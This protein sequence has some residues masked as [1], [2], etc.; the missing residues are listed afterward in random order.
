MLSQCLFLCKSRGYGSL[1]YV[2]GQVEARESKQQ[3][4]PVAAVSS[5]SQ[6]RQ[7]AAAAFSYYQQQ[8]AS[9]PRQRVVCY[10]DIVIFF[11]FVS[12]YLGTVLPLPI[13]FYML[14]NLPVSLR[15]ILPHQNNPW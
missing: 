3:Q 12:I 10:Q 2:G 5:G 8:E 7:P 1:V 11:L 6:Q 14:V 13:L 15:Y 4:Q 9:A